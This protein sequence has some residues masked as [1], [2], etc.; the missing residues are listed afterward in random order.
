MSVSET[1]QLKQSVQKA[2]KNVL[3]DSKYQD[4]AITFGQAVVTHYFLDQMQKTT[5]HG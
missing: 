1:Q 3:I 2:I 5:G 4:E